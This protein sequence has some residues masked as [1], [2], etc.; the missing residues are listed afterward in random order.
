MS[1]SKDK[2]FAIDQSRNRYFS[3]TFKREKVVEL[4]SKKVSVG[5]LSKLYEVS[6]TSIY[7]WLYLYSDLS[8]GTKTVLQMD[9]ESNK[10]SYYKQKLAELERLYGQKQ[11]EIDY[12]NKGFELASEDLGFDVK[13]KYATPPLSG[14]GLRAKDTGTK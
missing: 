7:K 10:T 1:K 4:V 2:K 13:K 5:E 9:S 14:S 8:Q 6:R 11:I 12:L 3:E